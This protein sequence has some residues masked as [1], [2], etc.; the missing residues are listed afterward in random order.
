MN[1]YKNAQRLPPKKGFR[2]M[3]EAAARAECSGLYDIAALLWHKATPLARKPV[4]AL[5]AEHRRQYCLSIIRNQW[6]GPG[7]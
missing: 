5:W 3:A 7:N 2:Q 4:N 6:S 1:Q